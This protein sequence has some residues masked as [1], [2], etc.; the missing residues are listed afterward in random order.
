[1]SDMLR[2]GLKT[3]VAGVQGSFSTELGYNM[4]FVL[5]GGYRTPILNGKSGP[6]QVFATVGLAWSPG[7]DG[8]R[9]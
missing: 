9:F 1:M 6:A 2:A 7:S 4:H 8:L 3:E 5:S